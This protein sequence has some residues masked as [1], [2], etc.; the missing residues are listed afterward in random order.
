MAEKLRGEWTSVIQRNTVGWASGP[1]IIQESYHPGVVRRRPG[2]GVNDYRLA[3]VLL[4]AST[5]RVG[6]VWMVGALSRVAIPF[7]PINSTHE[8]FN[9]KT[10]FN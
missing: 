5:G 6:L 10:E 8:F 3:G 2:H 7:P 9:M 1:D 4:V